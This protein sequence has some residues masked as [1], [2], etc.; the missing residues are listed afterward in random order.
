MNYQDA[1]SYLSDK[2]RILDLEVVAEA[3]KRW[4]NKKLVYYVHGQHLPEDLKTAAQLNTYIENIISVV[5][6]QNKILEKELQ[7]QVDLVINFLTECVNKKSI[8]KASGSFGKLRSFLSNS[9]YKSGK[10]LSYFNRF[11]Y[12]EIQLTHREY[13]REV[14]EIISENTGSWCSPSLELL[15]PPGFIKGFRCEKPSA[16][17]GLA[18]QII[19]NKTSANDLIKTIENLLQKKLFSKLDFLTESISKVERDLY[20]QIEPLE[21][22]VYEEEKLNK[23]FSDEYSIIHGMVTNIADLRAGDYVK[24]VIEISK[25]QQNLIIYLAMV[26]KEAIRLNEATDSWL[27]SKNV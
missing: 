14:S 4:Q 13:Y 24:K 5:E 19:F 3:S 18:G 26:V 1:V 27:K 8:T 23:R 16:S 22:S 2:K 7:E 12:L 11:D 17:Y 9:G 20:R 10:E 21:V 6:K 25:A 15:A